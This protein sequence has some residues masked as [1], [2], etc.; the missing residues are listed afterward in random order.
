MQKVETVEE[1]L[2]LQPENVRAILEKVRQAAKQAAPEAVEVISYQMPAF[3]LNKVF[4]FYAGFKNHYSFFVP[5]IL[6]AFREELKDYKTSKAAINLP[7]DRPVPV[8]LVKKLVKAA[9]K[10]DKEQA[11]LKR[12]KK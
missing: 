11:E 7:L 9:V 5:T 4:F 6:N 3:R 1:Y 10:H 8:A 2:A 12:K